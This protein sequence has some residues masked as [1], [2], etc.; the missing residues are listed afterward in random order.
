MKKR[1]ILF[2]ALM[3]LVF[4]AIQP[5]QAKAENANIEILPTPTPS[6]GM[7]DGL[8]TSEVKEVRKEAEDGTWSVYYPGKSAEEVIRELGLSESLTLVSSH[9]QTMEPPEQM[10]R[11]SYESRVLSNTRIYYSAGGAVKA[12]L[13]ESYT[14]WYFTTN[15]VHIFSRL[16]SIHGAA[17]YESSSVTYGN[18][19]NTDGSVSYVENCY[20]DIIGGGKT[21][22]HAINFIVT[23]S[24][25]NFY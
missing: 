10:M 21:E 9:S 24:Y 22:R 20:V 1:I 23:P 25:Y 16:L 13:E 5:M 8:A 11:D 14:V 19:V 4:S 7:P 2:V 12:V 3:L 17:G 18:A 6:I 15:K